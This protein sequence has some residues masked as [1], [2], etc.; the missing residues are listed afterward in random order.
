MS[1]HGAR[2]L[3]HALK[4]ALGGQD[5]VSRADRQD[6]GQHIADLDQPRTV[7]RR[8]DGNVRQVGR[9]PLFER[10]VD[11]GSNSGAI[12][13]KQQKVDQAVLQRRIAVLDRP[14]RKQRIHAAEQPRQ[15]NPYQVPAGSAGQQRQRRPT[16][17]GP[18]RNDPMIQDR[19]NQQKAQDARPKNHERAADIDQLDLRAR[20]GDLLVDKSIVSGAI[21]RSD[22]GPQGVGRGVAVRHRNP[23]G[24]AVRWCLTILL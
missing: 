15:H 16:P 18:Q 6:A 23:L 20:F 2:I 17:P 8:I 22:G 1:A 13:A 12:R 10:L 7:H 21:A 9:R 4:R 14:S 3:R 11:P 19:H 24:V 5:R